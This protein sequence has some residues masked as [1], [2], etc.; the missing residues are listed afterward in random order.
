[1]VIVRMA[2]W[3]PSLGEYFKKWTWTCWCSKNLRDTEIQRSPF[4]P[5]RSLK[6]TPTRWRVGVTFPAWLMSRQS[7][8][9]TLAQEKAL[10][11]VGGSK[12]EWNVV[13]K[14]FLEVSQLAFLVW[15]QVLHIFWEFFTLPENWGFHDP[16]W[17][18]YSS[19]G[20]VQPL[21]SF[22]LNLKSL[23]MDF[24]HH[25]S[26]EIW[27]LTKLRWN[28]TYCTASWEKTSRWVLSQWEKHCQSVG[29]GCRLRLNNALGNSKFYLVDSK[30]F[31]ENSSLGKFTAPFLG[32]K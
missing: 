19:G 24:S 12:T 9:W 21:T 3:Y 16:I 25:S 1:M 32:P 6:V 15:W 22:S 11:E 8:A 28:G 30:A 13:N 17:R 20:L 29:N 31:I 18:A 2:K 4:Q 23:T 14:K 7:E 27:T 26:A 10:K 5:I